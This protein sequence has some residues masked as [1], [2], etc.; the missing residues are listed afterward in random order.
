MFAAAFEVKQRDSAYRRVKQVRHHRD[1]SALSSPM[2]AQETAD[3]AYRHVE[4]QILRQAAAELLRES[5]YR[6]RMRF[7]AGFSFLG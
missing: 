5:F 6:E 2:T 4:R 3:A 7:H 1:S